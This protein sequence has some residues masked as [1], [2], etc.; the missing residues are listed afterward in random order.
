MR[1]ESLLPA[2]FVHNF[3]GW[4]TKI[5]HLSLVLLFSVKFEGDLQDRQALHLRPE[6][7]SLVRLE[8]RARKTALKNACLKL[9]WFLLIPIANGLTCRRFFPNPPSPTEYL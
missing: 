5:Q 1:R 8:N 4:R 7:L 2:N 6:L 9:A 3:D